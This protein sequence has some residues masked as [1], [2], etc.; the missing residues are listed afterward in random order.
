MAPEGRVTLLSFVMTPLLSRTLKAALY[1]SLSCLGICRLGRFLHRDQAL[2]LTYHGVLQKTH[3]GYSNRNCVD[4]QMFDRQM[5]FMKRHYN[6][7][8]LA[9]LAQWLST[10]KKMPAYTAAITFD[11]GF[12]NNFSIALPILRKYRLPATV[13]L[14]TSFIGGEE[15]GL[16]TEQV[17]RLLQDAPVEMVRIAVNGK[18]QE[19]Q[20]RSKTDREVASDRIRA[21][22]KTLS[23]EQRQS[24][25]MNLVEQVNVKTDKTGLEAENVSEH[26]ELNRQTTAEVEER[27]AFLTWQ[28]VQAMMLHQITFGSHTHTHSIM[29][30]LDEE[31]ANFE[32]AESRRLIEERLGTPCRLFSYPN[33]TTAD[34]GPREQRLLERHGYSAAVSQIDGFNNASTDLTA[35][36]RINVGRSGHLSFFVAKISGIWS[37]F[38]RLQDG[39]SATDVKRQEARA[40]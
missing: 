6:V 10:G 17:D 33:G 7:V 13:F 18:E 14:T 34:F 16:W 12:R 30:T 11:D 40:L 4:A 32:L 24:V 26:S 15:L 20:L 21:H 2:I 3:D 22:L 19:Y 29:A 39:A 37:L 23:P 38:K 35:L 27:Y 31:R 5:A 25:V 1:H 36:R 9:D 8:P 28:E